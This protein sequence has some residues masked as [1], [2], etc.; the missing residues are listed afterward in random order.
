MVRGDIR[1]FWTEHLNIQS[2]PASPSK[3][4]GIKHRNPPKPSMMPASMP[5]RVT[6][7]LVKKNAAKAPDVDNILT[8]A[9]V[10]FIVNNCQEGYGNKNLVIFYISEKQYGQRFSSIMYERQERRTVLSV[11]RDVSGMWVCVGYV[12]GGLRAH[13]IFVQRHQIREILTTIDP[14]GRA[15]HRRAA[16]RS[17][18][19]NVR[20]PNHMWHIVG[21]H[22]LVNWS[23]FDLFA[24][25]Y[26]YLPKINAS[27]EQFVEQWHFHEIRTAGYQCPRALWHA[28]ILHSMNGVVVYEPETYGI[29]FESGVSEVDDDYSVVVPEN[30][31]QLTE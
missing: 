13:G 3:A 31:I 21:N 17:R 27:L 30:Q 11:Q 12:S 18:Q 7:R 25:H 14:V 26:I 24:L 15:L 22:K 9:R 8:M 6:L 2:A 5:L 4:V 10:Y 29:A 16:I 19:Y 28:G 20:A 1:F 23:E